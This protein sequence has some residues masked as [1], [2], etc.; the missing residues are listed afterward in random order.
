MS[1]NHDDRDP[2]SP[3]SPEDKAYID[4]TVAALP[5]LSKQEQEDLGDAL[6]GIRI[7]AARRGR[8]HLHV[9]ILNCYPDEDV[10]EEGGVE[11]PA[12]GDLDDDEGMETWAY[13]HLFPLTGTGRTEGDAGYFV[14]IARSPD[15]PA[16]EGRQ[17]AWGI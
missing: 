7:R 11:V 8:I 5:P 6:A 10:A 3:L 15:L 2:K 12:P 14:T 13:D 4:K 17:F 16:L 1:D 9:T